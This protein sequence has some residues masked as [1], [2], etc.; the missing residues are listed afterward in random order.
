MP[1]LVTTMVS[2]I[3]SLIYPIS[4]LVN[5]SLPRPSQAGPLLFYSVEHQM[6]LLVKGERLGGIFFLSFIQDN[7]DDDKKNL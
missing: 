1:Q 2:Y 4:S 7:D 6:I 5:P 3:F